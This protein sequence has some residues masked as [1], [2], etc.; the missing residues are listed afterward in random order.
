MVRNSGLDTLDG[1]PFGPVE[2]IARGSRLL[3]RYLTA[4]DRTALEDADGVLYAGVVA[5][6]GERYL[7]AR[8]V[9]AHL[10]ALAED[11]RSASVW[12]VLPPNV[13]RAV[14]RAFTV[15][16]PSVST[17]W[18][19]Q[20]ELV[21]DQDGVSALN[22]TVRRVVLSV[23]TSS[24]KT[25][26]SQLF[27]L[28]HLA[29]STDGVC[30]VVPTRSL[31]REVRRD[32]RRRLRLYGGNVT[33]EQ[34]EWAPADGRPALGE[35]EV[36][37]PEG[38]AHLIRTGVDGLL[39]R[40]G[41]FIF[42]EAHGVG[43]GD[44]GFTVESC[45]SLLHWL[46]NHTHHRIILM[47][48]ALGNR[49]QIRSWVDPD[50]LGR[51]G[52]SDW[53]GPRRLHAIFNTHIDWE[54][55]PEVT[56]T[57]STAWP[58]FE[59][60]DVNGRVRLRPT[61]TGRVVDLLTTQPIGRWVVRLDPSGERERN[62][63]TGRMKKHRTSTPNYRM[64]TGLIQ[65]VGDAGPVL[66]VRSTRPQT[67]DLAKALAGELED[68]PATSGLAELAAGRVGPDHPLTGVLRRGVA[69]HHAGL[70]TDVLDAIEDA[71][72]DGRLR[73]VVSTTG[74]TDGV[75]LPVRTVIIDEPTGDYARPLTAAQMI[76]AV[77]RAGRACLESEGWAILVRQAAAAPSDFDRLDPNLADL[78]VRSALVQEE[79]LTSLAEFEELHRTT[80]D[81]VF[82]VADD[83]VSDFISFVWLVLTA[84]EE[85]HLPS[86]T[87]S[88]SDALP[89]TLAWK[90]LDPTTQEQWRQLAN[91]VATAY[92]SSDPARRRRWGR[93]ATS[94]GSARTLDN[95]VDAVVEAAT[96][97]TADLSD[98][99]ASVAL[100]EEG[101]VFD[102]L[103]ALPE[104]R[105]L[106]RI[107]TARSGVNRREVVVDHAALLRRWM[108]GAEIDHI[109][110][111]FL[112][113]VAA[114]DFRSE[115]LGDYLT[116]R[117]EHHLAWLVSAVVDWANTRLRD[118]GQEDRMLCADLGG[119]IRYGTGDAHG[120]ALL[121]RGVRSRRLANAV[122]HES[123][124]QGVTG[125]DG[126]Q[127]WLRTL[128]LRGWTE[129]FQASATDLR[130]L[131]DVVSDRDVRLLAQILEG[132][133]ARIDLHSAAG[134][135]G[136]VLIEPDE[137]GALRVTWEDQ[138]VA[139]I[140]MRHQAELR[141]LVET[142][143]S[144]AARVEEHDGSTILTIRL[145]E[146]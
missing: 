32:L 9:A 75:N 109:A 60:R 45:I 41:L 126:L 13:P 142:G 138:R 87:G 19:P 95:I 12:E 25:L 49:A 136:D 27:T 26:I 139:D 128:R 115:Q 101:N 90:Q 121:Q 53:R 114:R 110:D 97:S 105:S 82:R 70:P 145:I 37:T 61:R 40:F 38:L 11:F 62:P 124:Q 66:V 39:N 14:K 119:Y 16:R 35:V 58:A 103:F 22:P 54:A 46:T 81:A 51:A 144:F 99:W 127:E 78:E 30:Y 4:G 91:T 130:D 137:S 7:D 63:P 44:R 47:S 2:A 104:G 131:L 94:L 116:E 79:A 86:L 10:R 59:T 21:R 52:E 111:E 102:A 141:L 8:W 72:R 88:L 140:P 5:E 48:A 69:Y 143:M 36:L 42:D 92:E 3:M 96:R 89:A 20:I 55:T 6:G 76:N 43:E 28:C 106:N 113:E 120:L 24:G 65:L 107:F 122:A 146:E 74:L 67:R 17:L 34:H 68:N 29:Q 117:Y 134:A 100:L 15:G 31:A 135:V 125:F 123:R 77:G 112:G 56:S 83:R 98:P 84:S 33:P 118:R 93:I 132:E 129:L 133:S 1:S 85:L 50:H 108:E 64:L 23:P 73:Y 80:H 18:P 57:T 71:V